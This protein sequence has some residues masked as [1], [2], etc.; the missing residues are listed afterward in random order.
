METIDITA[1][2]NWD[3]YVNE[4]KYV[5]YRTSAGN[6]CGYHVETPAGM[7]CGWFGFCHFKRN[8]FL[9]KIELE[10][11]RGDYAVLLTVE[12]YNLFK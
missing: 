1:P 10:S 6:I 7:G 5:H 3:L 9:I 4:D 8:D 12:Q 2:A 11:G